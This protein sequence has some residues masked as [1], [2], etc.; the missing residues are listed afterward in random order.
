[1]ELHEGEKV[2]VIDLS[3]DDWWFVTKESSGLDGWVPANYLI[4]ENVYKEQ[5][6]IKNK[7]S[8][9]PITDGKILDVVMCLN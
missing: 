8:S 3:E 7:V 5:K 1:M 4:E 6:L 9:L 2:Y